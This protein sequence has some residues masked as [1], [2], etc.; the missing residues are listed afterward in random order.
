MLLLSGLL[1]VAC[2]VTTDLN[3]VVAVEVVLPDS[4]RIELTDTLL[5]TGRALNGLGDS[6]GGQQIYWAS[7]D[8]AIIAVLDSA[9][10]VT[11]TKS[12]GVG[13]LQARVGDLRS[14]PQ[15]VT[16]LARL[17]SMLALSAVRDTIDLA[18][19]S[20]GKVDSLSAPL[21]IAAFATGGVPSGRRVVYRATTFAAGDTV[22]TFVPNDSVLTTATST[23]AVGSTQLLLRL[24]AGP[25]PDS[26]L[27]TATM[28]RLDGTQIPGS[29]VTFVVAISP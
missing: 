15:N 24:H 19:D 18:P 14:N 26:V 23:S 6:V 1:L 7:L 16:V 4:G 13:R 5:A 2:K 27:V 8:T 11:I 25:V 22:V 10:G 12:V 21:Q 29:P 28:R 17:D 3:Q 9:S 20:T